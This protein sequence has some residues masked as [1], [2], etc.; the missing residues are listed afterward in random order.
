RG[1]QIRLAPRGTLPFDTE[2]TIADAASITAALSADSNIVA[3]SPV[4]GGQL[5][6]ARGDSTI[7][8]TL[9]GVHPRVQGDY[10]LLE[11]RDPD[12][13]EVVMSGELLSALGARIG[14]TLSAGTGYDPQLRQ[15]LRPRTL[16]SSGRVRFLYTDGG[17][18]GAAMPLE[19]MQAMIEAQRDRASLFMVQVRD[20][21]DVE[22]MRR[23]IESK[24]P[25]VSAISIETAIAQVDQRLS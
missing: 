13:G 2:A 8:A 15:L 3:V 5:H 14:D 19:A 21:V 1:Y 4:L 23:S 16:K 6:V 20:G 10:E 11:G 7:T 25:S 18:R 24:V 12:P 22:A 17:Q 9:L